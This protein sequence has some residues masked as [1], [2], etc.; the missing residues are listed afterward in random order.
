MID[1]NYIYHCEDFITHI[2]IE[3][4]H[5]IP[6]TNITLYINYASNEKIS[7]DQKKTGEESREAV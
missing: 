5:C 1:S 6:E 7:T 2:N 3:S 4:L